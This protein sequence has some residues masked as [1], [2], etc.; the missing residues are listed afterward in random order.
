[1]NIVSFFK[2]V[3]ERYN[4]ESKC[5]FCW[6][7]KA[8]LSESGLS[9]AQLREEDECCL[10]LFITD[11]ETDTGYRM[12]EKT[13]LSHRKYCD[14]S[15]TLYVVKP[16]D[17]GLNV[18]NEIPGHPINES[19]WET[20]LAPIQNCIGCGN[21]FDLCEMGYSFDILRWKMKTVQ[22]KEDHNYTGWR[23]LG[24]FR[25]FII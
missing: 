21:E 9:R 22:F 18:Y 25:Q 20:I 1:M 8:P 11:Y 2:Q 24:V 16:S 12:N 13:G 14:H 17:I 7:F 5:G 3:V 19:L 4:D 23:I 6:A 10:Q 15:F